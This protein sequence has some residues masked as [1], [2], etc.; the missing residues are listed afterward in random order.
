MLRIMSPYAR[1]QIGY[2]LLGLEPVIPM[3][4]V[5]VAECSDCHMARLA[6]LFEYFSLPTARLGVPP[7]WQKT[8]SYNY[9]YK[10][11]TKLTEKLETLTDNKLSDKKLREAT[12]SLNNIRRRLRNISELRKQQPPPIGGYDFIRLNHSS[13]YCGLEEQTKKLRKEL[14]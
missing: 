10:G 11:L 1:A 5:I 4:D 3:L 9:Y 2:H 8:I 12:E 14:A 13:F 7:D 6:D